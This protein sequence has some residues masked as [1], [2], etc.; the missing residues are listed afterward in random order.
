M[1]KAIRKDIERGVGRLQCPEKC[2]KH[3]VACQRYYPH[4]PV[5]LRNPPRILLPVDEHS[6][7]TEGMTFCQ[8][9]A[10]EAPHDPH[11]VT[12]VYEPEP[13]AEGQMR[14]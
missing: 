9:S 4:K 8:W 5:K 7:T 14:L 10:T 1:T 3:E 2:P 12:K 13:V 11:P 6:H